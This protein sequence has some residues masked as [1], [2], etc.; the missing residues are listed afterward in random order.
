MGCAFTAELSAADL[1][2]FRTQRIWPLPGDGRGWV[3]FPC[4]VETVCATSLTIPG[5]HSA[6]RVLSV[7]SRSIGLLLP[8]EF[9]PATLLYFQVPGMEEGPHSK[10]LLRV[11][12]TVEHSN[13]DWFHGCEF[14][15]PLGDE[16][17]L[18]LLGDRP[19]PESDRQ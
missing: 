12:R 11:V 16:I 19:D 14:T 7:S 15:E 17:L 6:A 2:I 4:N 1:H 5:E 8:C 9:E 18:T 10:L 3:R 13:G